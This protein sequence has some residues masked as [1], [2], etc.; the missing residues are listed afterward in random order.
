MV[1]LDGKFSEGTYIELNLLAKAKL[2]NIF[3][4]NK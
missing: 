4:E 3:F 1:F 2:E